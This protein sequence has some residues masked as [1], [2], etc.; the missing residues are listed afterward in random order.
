MNHKL[1][2]GNMLQ[3]PDSSEWA[4]RNV[5]DDPLIAILA[6]NDTYNSG[7]ENNDDFR[8]LLDM[9]PGL[10][11]PTENLGIEI[12]SES[13][14][15]LAMFRARFGDRVLWTAGV[16]VSALEASDLRCGGVA[17][18]SNLS[19]PALRRMATVCPLQKC[20]FR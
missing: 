17:L 14:K 3:Q 4:G 2:N 19:G 18:A 16:N 6:I 9:H 13:N 12:E 20:S 15:S 5:T 7:E 11:N 10:A 8:F 1:N